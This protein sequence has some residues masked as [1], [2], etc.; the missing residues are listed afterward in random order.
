MDCDDG[1]DDRS[2]WTG[3][4]AVG[5][6]HAGAVPTASSCISRPAGY[7]RDSAAADYGSGSSKEQ[8]IDVSEYPGGG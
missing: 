7:T 1:P 2:W 6:D 3:S 4:E 8:S 5:K